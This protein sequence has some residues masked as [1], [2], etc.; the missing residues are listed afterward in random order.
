[1]QEEML[2][3]YSFEE[4]TEII[5]ELRKKCP[6]DSVQ[7]HES[8]RECL[9]NETQEVLEG[10]QIL[11]ESGDGAN[12][13]E[14]LGDLLMQVLLHSVIAEEE[15]LF[16][17]E[18]VISGLAFKMKFRHPKIFSPENSKLT[19]LSWKELKQRE[20]EIRNKKG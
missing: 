20:R 11:T 12:L 9:E 19:A 10:I 3:K 16:T 8:M 18:D 17:L 1:M 15:G 5:R 4:L 14:E 2:R 6:W 13:C 7:T